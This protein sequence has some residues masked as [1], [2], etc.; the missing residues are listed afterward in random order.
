MAERKKSK[1]RKKDTMK[2]MLVHV[3]DGL[4]SITSAP[5][6]VDQLLSSGTMEHLRI[7]TKSVIGY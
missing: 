1:G 2:G 4:T 3:I 7:I 5:I 6:V